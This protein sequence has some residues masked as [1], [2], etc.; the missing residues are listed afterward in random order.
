MKVTKEQI[1]SSVDQL[2]IYR[3]FFR[4][5]LKLKKLYISPLRSEKVASFNVYRKGDRILYKDFGSDYQGDV[6]NFVMHRHSCSF[7]QAIDLIASQFNLSGEEAV[8]PRFYN[9]TPDVDFYIRKNFEYE[10]KKWIIYASSYQY[11]LEHGVVMNYL[12]EYDVRLVQWYSWINDEGS[13]ILVEEKPGI[14]I[15]AYVFDY[16]NADTD[17]VRFYSPY[18]KNRSQKHMGNLRS[19][20]VFGFKQLMNEPGKVDI[21]GILGG[22]KDALT[23]YANT[24]IRCVAPASESTSIPDWII[25]DIKSKSHRQFVMFDNDPAGKFFSQKIAK[26]ASIPV[27]YP[28]DTFTELSDVADY[29]KWFHSV[30]EE[31]LFQTV[32]NR[33]R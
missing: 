20:D 1:L 17:V 19:S 11:W 10:T 31:D 5:D 29:Y 21:V 8:N 6:F 30:E 33:I 27:I 25:E 13:K 3:A 22:Q 14:P 15:Y 28:E 2:E 26:Q 18:A 16:N 12:D 4:P 24:G 7:K 9:P 32:I 23:V